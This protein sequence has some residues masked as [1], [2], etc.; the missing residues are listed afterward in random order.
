MPK[1]MLN[2]MDDLKEIYERIKF[3]R[4]KGVKMKEIAERTGFPPSVLSAL[5]TTVLPAYFK[6]IDKGMADDEALDNALLW[7]NNVSKKKL[8]G[9]IG[10]TKSAL[11]A[12]EIAPKPKADV[13]DNVHLDMIE[14]AMKGSIN[15]ITNFSGTYMSYSV[16]SSSNAMKVEPYLIVPAENGNYVEVIHNNAYGS[17]HHGFALMNGLNHMYIIFNENRQPQLALFDICLKIPMF[18]RPPYLR[19]L[20][21]CFDY[22]YN[23]IARRIL[24]VKVSDSVSTDEF[25]AMKGCLK[26]E[27]ELDEREKVY[28]KY[29]C[30]REDVV[31]MRDIPSP[32]MTDDDLM[33]EKSLLNG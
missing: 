20:Y 7:V 33:A 13:T 17:T 22:N 29:T 23:P 3:L 26:H 9:S 18:D 10:K 5:F 27:D 32:K 2:V 30:S 8:L 24:F 31:R 28:Y 11:F 4:H 14:R 12:I 15:L 21:T 6:N 16:S 19:G 25:M 1:I